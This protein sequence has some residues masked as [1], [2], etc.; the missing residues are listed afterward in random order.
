LKGIK[1]FTTYSSV[2]CEI[3]IDG[4]KLAGNF[5]LGIITN[6]TSVAGFRM[7]ADGTTSIDDGLFEAI[8]IR[9]INKLADRSKVFTALKTPSDNTDFVIQRTAK[10]ITLS[11]EQP[12]K[13]TI[14]GEFG[15][16]YSNI[17]VENLHRVLNIIM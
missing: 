10:R 16:E 1:N 15:G 2:N 5:V 14:D 9:R 4:E 8:F 11:F 7:K 12:C 6:V 3:D 13:W 17:T